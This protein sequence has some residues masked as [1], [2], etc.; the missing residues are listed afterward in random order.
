MGNIN[1]IYNDRVQYTLKNK[2]FDSLII[3]EP[4]GWKDDEKEYSRHENYHGIIAK[5]SNSLKFIGSGADYIQ[6]VLDVYGINEEIQLIREEMHPHTNVL[7][8]TYSGFLDLSTWAKEN[9]QV[10]VKFNSGGLEQ[11]LKSRESE[12]IEID[13]LTTIDGNPIPALSTIPVELEGRRIFL[14]TKYTVKNSENTVVMYN[15][16]N[17]QTRG[18][19]Y[20]TPL[21]L[22]NKSHENAH[23]P[24]AGSRVGDDT[25]ER[26]GNGE[27][28]NMFFAVSDR[29]RA[30]RIKFTLKFKVIITAFDDINFFGFWC[31][32]AQYQNG[33][34]Y[35]IKQNR[36]LYSTDN[37]WAL[38]GNTFTLNFDETINVSA[39]DSLALEF[40]Q[41]FDGSN[42]HSAHL[43]MHI[44][45]IE[46]DL[47]LE[48]NSFHEKTNTKAILAHEIADRLV[49]IGTNTQQAFYSDFLG[50]TDIGYNI[51]GKAALTAFTHGFW[52]RGFDKLPI[53]TE[54]PPKV[55]NLFKPLTTSFKE[56][57]ESMSAVWNIGI[58]IEKVGFRERVR[59]EELSYFYNRN[60]T[61]KLPNQV[62]NVKRTIA[63]DKYYSSLELGFKEGGDYEEACGL[64][65]YNVKST[66]TTFINRLKNSYVKLSSYR[67]DSYGMEFARR[68][69]KSL[70]DTEDTTY[71]DK[72]FFLD[73]K[74]FTPTLFK[75]RKWGD[76]FQNAPT[77][78]FSP[79]TATNLRFS[80]FNCMLRHGWWIS[81]GLKKYL[82]EYVRYGSSVSNSQLKTKLRTDATYVNN[83]SNTP[84]N[85]NEY[86]ENGNIINSELQAPRFLPE[87]IEFEHICDFE[88]MQQVNGTTT[89]LGKKIPNFYGLVE[90]INERNEIE[91]GF[92]FN[93][94]PNGKGQWKVLKANR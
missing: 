87:E 31:R 64:D 84:G 36:M 49:T 44:V 62:K 28:G 50:R 94:K 55:E 20:T 25:W 68:K 67:A 42:G 92:L 79:E 23:S 56:F 34:N 75:Q 39:G 65:E 19:T 54:G 73:L 74:R 77:G 35:N 30:L 90:F 72:I 59:L 82:T 61:I 24:I 93:L 13:R 12:K 40:D 7:T 2:N 69:Q 32:L 86:A 53:P 46:C 14:K 3:T 89:I 52:V 37:Y 91:K 71:D 58:G 16:T 29:D 57:V 76:D 27:T 1:P 8:L 60:V 11:L 80:P 10:S 41:N 83:L 17:G 51:D 6:L 47:T 22:V 5:F 88:V 21:V 18:S 9:N 81:G 43:D 78:I 63:A 66:F 45:N 15:Q 33:S 4:I 48:E 70:N 38:Q 85:G 26:H